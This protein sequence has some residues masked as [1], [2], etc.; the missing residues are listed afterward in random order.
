M[1]RKLW[2][3]TRITHPKHPGLVV[4]VGEYQSGGTLHVF[5]W[6]RGKQVSRSLKC[7]RVDLGTTTRQQ[8]REAR[9]LGAEFI[10]ELASAPP[11]SGDDDPTRHRLRGPLTL[12]ALADRY[13]RDGFAGRTKGYKRD[14]LASIRRVAA[15]LG[16]DL[17]IAHIKPSHLARYLAAR[18][19]EGHAP[20]GRRDLVATSIA[21]NW[22]CGEELIDANPL[23]T[24]RA[25]DAMRIDHE[26]RRPVVTKARYAALCQVAPQLPPAFLPLLH[27]AWHTGHRISAILGLRWEHIVFTATPDAPHGRITWYAGAIRNRKRHEHTL[28][29]N[30]PAHDALLAWQR[31]RGKQVGAGWVFPALK[32]PTQPLDQF[33][34]RTWMRKA[35]R[36][37]KLPHLD[38][39]SWHPFRRG[40]A[41]ARKA[42][43]LKDV[44]AGG[45]WTDTATVL[46]SYQHADAEATKAATTFVA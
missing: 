27:L 2:S 22:A 17:P 33:P 25:R 28:P 23:A 21:L 38:G 32:D 11:E 41:T 43:P 36:L 29:M 30:K 10:E 31:R 5:R 7:R 1:K 18:V 13:E 3:V 35:E 42:L 9:R 34:P 40:W 4:R 39:G 15:A 26:P 12:S 6:V 44:A 37:A 45:G 19:A 46:K 8:E 14:A 16:A 24:K 20:A